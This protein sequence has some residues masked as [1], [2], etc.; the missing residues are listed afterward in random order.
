MS[1]SGATQS[2]GALPSESDCAS[3]LDMTQDE[4]K[5]H[6]ADVAM[7]LLRMHELYDSQG[8]IKPGKALWNSV[9][10]MVVDEDIKLKLRREL[11]INLDE[12]RS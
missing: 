12:V 7:K 11:T 1:E 4:R 8:I 6:F 10:K 3:Q 2:P 5:P 9:K